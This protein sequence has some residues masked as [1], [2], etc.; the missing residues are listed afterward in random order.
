MGNLEKKSVINKFITFYNA[1]K[2]EQDADKRW[3]LWKKLY[4]FAPMVS[5]RTGQ[6]LTRRKLESVWHKYE[7][8]IAYLMTY[9]TADN[10]MDR[11]AEEVCGILKINEDFHSVIVFYV[12]FYDKNSFIA[13]YDSNR[14]AV[15]FPVEIEL[16]KTEIIHE[17]AHAAHFQKAGVQPKYDRQ[18]ARII[19]E[20]GIAARLSQILLPGYTEETYVE[21]TPGWLK[22]CYRS[23]ADIFRGLRPYI[24]RKDRETVNRFTIQAGTSGNLREADFAGWVLI[25]FALDNGMPLHYFASISEENILTA[26]TELMDEYQL[27]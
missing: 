22:A 18:L 7:K 23:E 24:N 17:L 14:M 11:M 4:R 12:G 13:P 10:E 9:H 8:S 3:Q 19:L 2:L 15:C 27:R 1:A 26:V 20:E 16:T 25:G 6:R 21:E 5:G